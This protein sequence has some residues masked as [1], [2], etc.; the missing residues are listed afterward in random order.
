MLFQNEEVIVCW[1]LTTLSRN[2]PKVHQSKR[3]AGNVCICMH[4]LFGIDWIPFSDWQRER[5]SVWYVEIQTNDASSDHVIVLCQRWISEN[6]G[7]STTKMTDALLS[8]C[9]VG[10]E[11]ALWGEERGLAWLGTL[12]DRRISWTSLPGV[13]ICHVADSPACSG[14]C[15]T[16][17]Q[18]K[19]ADRLP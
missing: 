8:A 13:Y 2:S 5:E 16:W 14:R 1:V 7:K 9:A 15:F 4:Q 19:L 18:G 12:H 6:P 11:K 3:R 17:T 10:M